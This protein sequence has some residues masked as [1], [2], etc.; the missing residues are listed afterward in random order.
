VRQGTILC[1]LRFGQ[2]L[3]TSYLHRK[4]TRPTGTDPL[5]QPV[6]VFANT[7][8]LVQHHTFPPGYSTSNVQR[9]VRNAQEVETA[10]QAR[11]ADIE[12]RCLEL[13]PPL[14]VNDLQ[15]I[16]AFRDTMQITNPMTD[17]QWE[18]MLKPKILEEK[19]AA[20][21][22]E[23]QLAQH[24]AIL[25]AA[26]LSTVPDETF[27]R[28]AKEVYDRDY[29]QSQETLRQKLG[30]Y[31]SDHINGRWLQGRA[32]D[33]DSAPLF[34]VDVLLH[35][36]Q[37]YI[38]DREA[39]NLSSVIEGAPKYQLAKQSTPPLEPFLSLDN[40]KWVFD[41]KVRSYTDP[42][43]REL[44]ICAGC[45]EDRKPK[46]FAFEGLIQHYGAKHTSAFSKGN[47]VV[48]W[49]TAEW[50]E[51]PPF[52]ED[53]AAFVKAERKFSGAKAHGRSKGTPQ[54]SVD[55]TVRSPA[56]SALLDPQTALSRNAQ[57]HAHNRHTN[58]VEPAPAP[59]SAAPEPAPVYAAHPMRSPP[60]YRV[61][62]ENEEPAYAQAHPHH[63]HHQA[64]DDQPA[65]V[66]YVPINS[67]GMSYRYEQY[68]PPP[69]KPKYIDQ[70]GRPVELIP[71]DAASGPAQ[72]MPQSYDLQQNQQHHSRPAAYAGVPQYP[73]AS[74][75]PVRYEQ[76]PPAH[77]RGYVY[78]DDGRGGVPRD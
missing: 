77:Q 63:P 56:P 13:D 7:Q 34:A 54:A 15:H 72:Y 46:W 25:Q 43:R 74:Q 76:V 31:A 50:P 44:F 69:P 3:S 27:T 9:L 75:Q 66:Q 4:L 2:L 47:V 19:E 59:A 71:L 39:G 33:R 30:E 8:P 48:H 73:A 78:E 29:E 51:E 16:K 12:R 67:A 68:P 21:L 20:E 26:M 36:R 64:Y 60:R 52:F 55:E 70:Y 6:H 23:H 17:A 37:R 49:R 5:P 40:M 38:A 57:H 28:P 22:L 53:P 35:V 24:L 1:K 62:W 42:F 61:V 14:Q 45:A 65:P 10:R 32:L 11:R 58:Y 18:N 41:N